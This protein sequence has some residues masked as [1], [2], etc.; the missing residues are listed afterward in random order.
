MPIQLPAGTNLSSPQIRLVNEWNEGLSSLD[1]ELLSKPLHKD[2][3]HVVYPKSIGDPEQNKEGW[4]KDF[5]G[6]MGLATGFDVRYAL[7]YS[8]S[9]PRLNLLPRRSSIP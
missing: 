7:R 2:F 4:I 8:N 9:L 6:F 3:R 1:V 5:T